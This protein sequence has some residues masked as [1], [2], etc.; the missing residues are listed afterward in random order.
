[1]ISKVLLFLH[2]CGWAVLLLPGLSS[3]PSYLP[4]TYVGIALVIATGVSLGV[5]ELKDKNKGSSD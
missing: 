3:D 4:Y 2:V 5:S 1:M